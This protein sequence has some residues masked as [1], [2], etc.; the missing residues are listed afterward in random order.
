MILHFDCFAIL[1]YILKP[2]LRNQHEILVN[3]TQTLPNKVLILQY[4]ATLWNESPFFFLSYSLS[5]YLANSCAEGGQ[6]QQQQQQMV[7]ICISQVCTW[8]L[9]F[10]L[11]SWSVITDTIQLKSL[12]FCE[13][14]RKDVP[15]I[16][17]TINLNN[18]VNG[19]FPFWANL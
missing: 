16:T 4:K 19:Y 8:N 15:N 2:Q 11:K 7:Q 17:V 13:H 10:D 9:L 14:S 5:K 18:C 3:I 6:W 1:T 12:Q